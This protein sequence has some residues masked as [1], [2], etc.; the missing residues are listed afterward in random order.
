MSVPGTERLRGSIVPLVTPFTDGAIDT[1]AFEAAVERQVTEG[2]H[3][4]VVTGTTGEPT[5]L[6]ADERTDLYRR[7]V[8]VAA[9]RIPVVAATGTANQAE[10]IALTQAA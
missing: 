3:G 5:S 4:V 7:A 2:S 9:G 8:S 6:S 1:A 10:T